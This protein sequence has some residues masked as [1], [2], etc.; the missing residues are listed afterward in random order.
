MSIPFPSAT[1]Q[2]QMAAAD[3]AMEE[4]FDPGTVEIGDTVTIIGTAGSVLASLT[5]F[6][7]GDLFAGTFV[8]SETQFVKSELACR[9]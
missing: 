8:L 6:P 4:Y 9:T 3:T 2:M 7:I 1:E 5:L